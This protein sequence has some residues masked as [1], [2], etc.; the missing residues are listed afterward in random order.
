MFLLKEDF[1]TLVKDTNLNQIIE[2]N[3]AIFDTVAGETIAQVRSYLFERY[4][5]PTIFGKTG[6]ERDA[7]LMKL[8]K[9]IAIYELYKRLPKYIENSQRE[10][11]YKEA[12]TAL[13]K[14]AAGEVGLDLPRKVIDSATNTNYTRRRFGSQPPRSH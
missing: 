7:Y 6:T 11:D 14:I 12:I 8:C 10:L 3:N 1:T 9:H 5:T 2:N 13:E 4:D